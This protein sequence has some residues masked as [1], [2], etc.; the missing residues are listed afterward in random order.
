GRGRRLR[1][2]KD[3]NLFPT[4]YYKPNAFSL[5]ID[6]APKFDPNAF[7][8]RQIRKLRFSGNRDEPFPQEWLLI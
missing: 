5:S 6:K 4:I 2:T 8:E 1:Q 7:F 3:V